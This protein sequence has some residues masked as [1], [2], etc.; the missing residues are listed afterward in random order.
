MKIQ[1]QNAQ[2]TELGILFFKKT[3]HNLIKQCVISIVIQ[4]ARIDRSSAF[5]AQSTSEVMSGRRKKQGKLP[6]GHW[7][8]YIMQLSTQ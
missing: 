7:Y 8:L 6:N 3:K 2:K 4:K 1:D 5:N